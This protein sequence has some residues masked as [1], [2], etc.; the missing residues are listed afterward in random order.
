MQA[1]T[2]GAEKT[3]GQAEAATPPPRLVKAAHQFEAMMMNE[4]LKP[5]TDGDGLGSEDGDSDSG[6]GSGGALSSFASETL[7][8]AISASGGL[9]IANEII[10]SLSRSGN[11][12]AS[13]KVTGDLHG[14][15]VM[16]AL[17]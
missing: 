4:L 17:K 14:N 8:Q 15:T 9:G 1:G 7:G 11:Q 13:G 5:M 12:H 16:R 6:A 10:H 3:T 2:I